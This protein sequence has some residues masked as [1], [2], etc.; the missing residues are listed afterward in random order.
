M[1]GMMASISGLVLGLRSPVQWSSDWCCLGM[2]F[3]VCLFR[4]LFNCGFQQR[5]VCGGLSLFYRVAGDLLRF[6]GCLRVVMFT[7]YIYGWLTVFFVF[8]SQ[9]I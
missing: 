7:F 4:G 1:P 8:F 9:D 6:Q 3:G 2:G 5:G